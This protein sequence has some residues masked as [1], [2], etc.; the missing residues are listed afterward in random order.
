MEERNINTG[1][2][3][4]EPVGD[5]PYY[6]TASASN[7]ITGSSMLSRGPGVTTTLTGDASIVSNSGR[8]L[9]RED[10]N[11]AYR[12]YIAEALEVA[13]KALQDIVDFEEENKAACFD[14]DVISRQKT[15]IA[16]KALQAIK[17]PEQTR[18]VTF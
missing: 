11:V 4:L 17:L 3:L 13:D 7:R 1:V 18:Q 8:I 12:D 16:L 9:G 10:Q 2:F 6:D 14:A 15:K 5:I